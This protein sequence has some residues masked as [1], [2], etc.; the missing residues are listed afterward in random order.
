MTHI[1]MAFTEAQTARAE[2]L[3]GVL[4][5]AGYAVRQASQD[6]HSYEAGIFASAAVVLLWNE[7][8]LVLQD[9]LVYAV[10]LRKPIFALLLDTTPFP[11]WLTLAGQIAPDDIGA[12]LSA[13]GPLQDDPITP[14]LEQLTH[15]HIPRRLEGVKRLGELAEAENTRERALAL[16]GAVARDNLYQGVQVAAQKTLEQYAQRFT[17]Q[18]RSPQDKGVVDARCYQCGHTSY[19]NKN[20]LCGDTRLLRRQVWRGD[21]A[22]SEVAVKCKTCNAVLV[23]DLDCGG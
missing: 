15:L 23:F 7:G 5:A 6:A 21:K 16:L 3:R 22:M 17:P 4:E 19:F 11:D 2:G 13:L 10:N 20:V 14:V 8:A 12:L 9:A 18:S 1:F